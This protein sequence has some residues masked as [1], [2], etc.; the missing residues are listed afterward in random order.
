MMPLIIGCGYAGE[1]LARLWIGQSVPVTGWVKRTE[2]ARPL[3]ELGAQPFV[4]D[5]TETADWARLPG[6]FT[7]AVYSVSSSRGGPEAYR[8]VYLEGLKLA[9]RHLPKASLL[10][11]SSTS[12]YGQNDGS[13]VQEDSTAE[14][15]SETGQILREAEDFA[16]SAG[17]RVLRVAGIYGPGRGVLY[18][19]FLAGEAIIEGDGSRHMNQIHVEDL[20]TAIDAVARRGQ[21]GEIYNVADHHPTTYLDFYTW[22]ANEYRRPLP[23]FGPLN[24]Q[25][26]RGVTNKRV[27]NSRL[28]SLGWIPKYE[29]FREGLEARG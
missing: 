20:A 27:D 10:F 6:E 26:K 1:A 28:R 13:T 3:A 19:K 25:R 9:R 5:V 18:Q 23:P 15:S 22:L 29:S 7:H 2:S 21:D 16:L 8:A 24:L 14:P 17:A 12:V 11:V 4:G